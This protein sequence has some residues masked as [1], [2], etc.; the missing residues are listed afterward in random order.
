MSE[1]LAEIGPAPFDERAY[2]RRIGIVSS[3]AERIDP[4]MRMSRVRQICRTWRIATV[5][6]LPTT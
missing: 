2:H 3:E 5:A 1:L 6:G 4:G